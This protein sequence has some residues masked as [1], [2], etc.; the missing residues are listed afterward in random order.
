[1]KGG[2]LKKLEGIILAAGFQLRYEKGR[3]ISGSCVL[4]EQKIVI[5]NKF[6]N[7]EDRVL[8]L[9]DLIK[10]TGIESGLDKETGQWFQQQKLKR[11]N[12]SD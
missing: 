6:F 8:I 12:L 5:V 2:A 1:M 9:I 3:F 4:Q 10:E 7:V 11:S